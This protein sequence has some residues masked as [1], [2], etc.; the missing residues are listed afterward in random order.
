MKHRYAPFAFGELDLLKV[1]PGAKYDFDF[2]TIR[3]TSS[4]GG[5]LG[6]VR[7]SKDAYRRLCRWVISGDFPAAEIIVLAGQVSFGPFS[8]LCAAANSNLYSITLSKQ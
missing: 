4:G 3:S 5:A 8:D 2:T 6:D 7:R 1:G